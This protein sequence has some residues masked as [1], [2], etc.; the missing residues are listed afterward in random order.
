MRLDA[1]TTMYDNYKAWIT[2]QIIEP[3]GFSR[4]KKMLREKHETRILIS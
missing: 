2:M 3:P 4:Y 1:N